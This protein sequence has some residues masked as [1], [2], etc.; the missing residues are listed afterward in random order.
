MH[1][2]EHLGRF[3][4]EP[5]SLKPL[6]IL[7]NWVGGQHSM[8][9]DLGILPEESMQI[10]FE[11][12][13]DDHKMIPLPGSIMLILPEMVEVNQ[14]IHIAAAQQ[15]ANHQLNYLAADYSADGVFTLLTFAT[16]QKQI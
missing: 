14:P 9:T 4:D 12:L 6:N 15:T 1:I 7:G 2:R 10:S 11:Q 13:R 8:S 3:S 16:L 5:P